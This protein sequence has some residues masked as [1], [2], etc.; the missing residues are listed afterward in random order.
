MRRNRIIIIGI[1]KIGADLLRK[2][3]K[4]HELLCI[5]NAP[6]AGEQAKKLRSEGVTVMQADA[7]SRLVLDEAGV[8]EAECVIVTTTHE[9]VN[10]EVCRLLREHFL[11]KRVITVGTSSEGIKRLAELGA[12]VQDLFA[13]S[14]A[15]IRNLLEHRTRTATSIGLG[16]NEILEVE[17]HPHSRLA[18]KPL[19]SLAPLRWKIG[20]I[21]RDGNIIVP[22]GDTVLRPKDR[23][24]ILGDPAVLKTV[25][26]IMT[27]SFQQFPL[28]YGSTAFVY[29][30]GREEEGF[31]SELE[32]LFDSFPLKRVLFIYSGRASG[33]TERYHTLIK[34]ERYH[35]VEERRIDLPVQQA[36]QKIIREEHHECAIM[37]L[38][39][40]ILGSRLLPGVAKKQILELCT[41]ASCPVL[42]ARGTHP[43]ERAAVPA[44]E[45]MNPQQGLETALEVASSLNNAVSALLVQPIRH[46]ASDADAQEYEA[47]RKSIS[48]LSLMYRSEVNTVLLQG[49]P[50]RALQQALAGQNLLFLD[51]NTLKKRAWPFPF[52]FLDPDPVWLLL[53]SATVSTMLVPP[54]E[55][56]L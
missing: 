9:A 47:S 25:S 4:D 36:V 55:E 52:S 29:L 3:P 16:K 35:S 5:D 45:G 50:V 6:D 43:Y 10:I 27:F 1:G 46:I 28:E 38:H 44:A 7:T 11:P 18:N 22:H 40:D 24:I 42:I 49:N 26:E 34:R 19:R 37:V 15:S 33:Q 51:S 53:R 21:Y 41:T 2:F 48:E 13:D 30:S 20:V 39:E 54:V 32:Y 23:M 56:A 14:A 31:F 8:N 17:L 12:E